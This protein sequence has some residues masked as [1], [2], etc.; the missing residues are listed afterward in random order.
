MRMRAVIVLA[1]VF[2]ALHFGLKYW[3]APKFGADVE[4]RFVERLKY[5]PS[6]KTP[7]VEDGQQDSKAAFQLQLGRRSSSHPG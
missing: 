5:I 1:V 6:F 4:A 7:G 3:V 2:A